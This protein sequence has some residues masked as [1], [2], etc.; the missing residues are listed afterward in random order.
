MS[1]KAFILGARSG[2]SDDD[3]VEKKRKYSVVVY[4]AFLEVIEK[5]QYMQFSASSLHF[6][7]RNTQRFKTFATLKIQGH[8]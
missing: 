1:C 7:Y 6:E 4:W 3:S 8:S 2:I 5:N